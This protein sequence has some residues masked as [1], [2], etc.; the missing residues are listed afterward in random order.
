MTK[1]LRSAGNSLL[2]N[3]TS[4]PGRLYKFKRV[5]Q[6]QSDCQLHVFK[7]KVRVLCAILRLYV[8]HLKPYVL[9]I[10]LPLS[11]LSSPSG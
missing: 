5:F 9:S 7:H 4:N 8:D 11:A 10:M 6:V 2:N 1:L 3:T